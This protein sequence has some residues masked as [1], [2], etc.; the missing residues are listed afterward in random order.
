MRIVQINMVDFGST[1]KIML[2]IAEAA[3]AQGAQ[4]TTFSTRQQSMRYTRLPVPKAGHAYYGSFAGNNLHYLLS[5]LTGK[6]GCYSVLDTWQ[7]IRKLRAL[8]PDVIHLHNL[9]MAFLNLP[10]LFG[11][12]KKAGIPVVWTL[13]DCWSFTGKCPHFVYEKCD[14]WK[15]GCTACPQ[16]KAYPRSVLDTTRT[17]WHAKRKWYAGVNLTLVPPSKWLAGLIAQ[18]IV[19]DAAVRVI[20]NGIDLSV[21]KPA[22]SDFRTQHRCEDRYVILGVAF[23][24]NEKKGLDVFL[25]LAQSLDARYQIVLAGT[26]ERTDARLPRNIVS[27]HRTQSPQELAQLYSA[28]DLFVNP[29]RED[30]YPTVNMESLACGTPVLTFRTGGSPEIIDET[31]GSVVDCDDVSALK[32][33]IERICTTKPYSREACLKRAESFDMNRRYKE[34]VQLYAQCAQN[35]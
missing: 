9:H 20:P 31:C 27:V 19:Q 23:G 8:K 33:E 26:D 35:K 4:V 1:G 24:W 34:Y 22:C 13:H 25:E 21:F 18:S 11:Y 12:V 15:T 6:Y 5:G 16:L 28:A 17:M 3:R 2:Q 30:T 7:L 29:T 14:K 32:E 10:M